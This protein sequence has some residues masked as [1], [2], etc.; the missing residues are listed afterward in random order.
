MLSEDQWLILAFLRVL[1]LK[2]PVAF[3]LW[4]VTEVILPQVEAKELT[5]RV[6]GSATWPKFQTAN[7]TLELVIK[8]VSRRLFK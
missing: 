5:F 4:F 2:I 1:L 6:A 7:I 8:I 3:Y